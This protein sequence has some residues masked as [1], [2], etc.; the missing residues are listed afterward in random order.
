MLK[1]VVEFEYKAM[2]NDRKTTD[3]FSPKETTPKATG[4][5]INAL[6]GKRLLALL[7]RVSS[8]SQLYP[9]SMAEGLEIS[10][11]YHTLME[12][13]KDQNTTLSPTN[14]TETTLNQTSNFILVCLFL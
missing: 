4:S 11:L 13:S 6:M 10:R 5:K 12:Q 3:N 14:S 8:E 2:I 1:E 7:E 9:R